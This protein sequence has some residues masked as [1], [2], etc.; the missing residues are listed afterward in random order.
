MIYNLTKKF[1]VTNTET[2]LCKTR[3]L[4]NPN[5]YVITHKHLN[6]YMVLSFGDLNK[7]QIYK[8][9]YRDKHIKIT[10]NLCVNT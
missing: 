4:S 6:T 1:H 7:A 10:L 8:M 3:G 9:H 5:T 2:L